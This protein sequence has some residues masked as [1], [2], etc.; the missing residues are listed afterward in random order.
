[1]LKY[2]YK[3]SIFIYRICCKLENIVYNL[4]LLNKN[5]YLHILTILF[6]EHN[7]KIV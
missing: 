3:L 2:F 1:M 6:Y 5:K 7:W 4:I